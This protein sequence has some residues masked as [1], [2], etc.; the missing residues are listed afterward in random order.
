MDLKIT[1]GSP[2]EVFCTT[3]KR[4]GINVDEMRIIRRVSTPLSREF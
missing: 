2:E 4:E 1:V 3:R